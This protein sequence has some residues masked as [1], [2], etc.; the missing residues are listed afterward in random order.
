M[1]NTT[2]FAWI[3]RKDHVKKYQELT[4]C[5][6][7]WFPR[8]RGGAIVRTTFGAQ[9]WSVTFTLCILEELLVR[10]QSE[11]CWAAT[12]N[13][14]NAR[15]IFLL[16][17]TWDRYDFFNA[18]QLW[19][20]FTLCQRS[21]I[22]LIFS[23]KFSKVVINHF[24]NFRQP[25]NFLGRKISGNNKNAAI[26]NFV[27]LLPY[28]LLFTYFSNGIVANEKKWPK[29]VINY[30]RAKNISLPSESQKYLENAAFSEGECYFIQVSRVH[31]AL[32]IHQSYVINETSRKIRF[33]CQTF[34]DNW[35]WVLAEKKCQNCNLR[36]LRKYWQRDF[37]WNLY[38]YG[39]S[40]LW[41][42]KMYFERRTFRLWSQKF[43]QVCQQT[44]NVK[45]WFLTDFS[46]LSFYIAV[47]KPVKTIS[48]HFFQISDSVWWD[49]AAKKNARVLIFNQLI[50]TLKY[51]QT[52]L[53]LR[54]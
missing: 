39:F 52:Y 16:S 24:H 32:V 9:N 35:D 2:I 42:K 27:A 15:F 8:R 54:M 18:F 12:M 11:T 46:K 47:R 48:T 19:G 28:Y 7:G 6:K 45:I 29:V 22:N 25:K 37:Q 43:R 38:V 26:K 40:E 14:A 41:A 5:N 23:K 20:P 33:F 36:V 34:L 53:P 44:S 1:Q 49:Q 51:K 3:H 50:G 30:A 31:T 4:E 13:F 10:E 21:L 17:D